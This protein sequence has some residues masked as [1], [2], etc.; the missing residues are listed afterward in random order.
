MIIRAALT[1]NKNM[2]IPLAITLPLAAFYI[3]M[4]WEMANN[5][6]LPDTSTGPMSWP[7]ATKLQWTIVFIVLNVLGAGFYF[8]TEYKK[9]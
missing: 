4:F 8:F 5:S 7:P 6:K 2:F 3:W 1:Y 9:R